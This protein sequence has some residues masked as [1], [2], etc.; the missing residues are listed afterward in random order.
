MHGSHSHAPGAGHS[1]TRVKLDR[2]F[3]LATVLNVAIVALEV[4][5]GFIANSVA[6]IADA[7]HNASDIA[8][9]LL[10]WGA[11]RLG[12]H[13]PT[14]RRTYGYANASVLAALINAA[15]LLAALG[16][17]AFEALRRLWQPAPV[18]SETVL[19]VALIAIVINGATALLFWKGRKDDLN[20]RGAF[21]HM[22]TDAA[23]S[24]GVVVGALAISWTGLF[25]IDPL[26]SLAIA[27]VIFVGAWSMLRES[28]DL[29]LL[30]V[31]AHI[32]R[33]AV[34]RDLT[35]LP[36][37]TAV[38]HLH[39]WALSTTQTALTAH[40]VRPGVPADSTFLADAAALL[41][42]R[43]S[44]DHATLQVEN[45]DAGCTCPLEP[46]KSEQSDD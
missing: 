14:G 9:L 30:A 38:H 24:A 18:E 8:A 46:A 23:V 41:K 13:R 42:T 11:L 4:G 43:H 39:I 33:A 44:I 6:L 22:A 20:V 5:Y 37:V 40:I 34:E 2:T 35:S 17:I 31:P 36:G 25:W 19:W 10:A 16:A 12:Q 27:A 45:P 21:L 29:A 28:A 3:A 15:L 26:V 1:H 32:D 7:I